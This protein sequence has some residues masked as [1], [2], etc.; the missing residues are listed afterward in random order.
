MT[1]LND[2]WK[3][4]SRVKNKDDDERPKINQF[5]EQQFSRLNSNFLLKKFS[6]EVVLKSVHIMIFVCLMKREVRVKL[7][8]RGWWW[9]WCWCCYWSPLHKQVLKPEELQR[10]I[11]LISELN[12]L[13]QTKQKIEEISRRKRSKFR[14]KLLHYFHFSAMS[15]VNG[16]D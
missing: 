13:E 6:A 7:I 14:W 1:N 3:Y 5:F 12:K 10:F 9:W 8:K 4:I 11:T 2:P 15:S 16:R